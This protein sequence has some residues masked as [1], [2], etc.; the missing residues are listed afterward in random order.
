M[1]YLGVLQ[2]G[3]CGDVSRGCHCSGV[4]F[5]GHM[6]RGWPKALFSSRC[7]CRGNID[8]VPL[9]FCTILRAALGSSLKTGGYCPG[10]RGGET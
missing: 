7:Y 2:D 6:L 1:K 8:L 5:G 9:P 3:V 10:R 4:S